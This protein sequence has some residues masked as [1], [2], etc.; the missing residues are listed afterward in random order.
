MGLLAAVLSTLTGLL[1]LV[2]LAGLLPATVLAA[3]TALATLLAALVL[4]A[5]FRIVRHIRFLCFHLAGVRS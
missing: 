1:S 2:L 5:L 4:S 3:L